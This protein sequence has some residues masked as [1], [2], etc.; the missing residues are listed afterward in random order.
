MAA[1]IQQHYTAEEYLAYERQAAYKSEYIAGQILAMSGASWE[2]SPS[3]GNL[4]GVLSTQLRDRPGTVHASALRVKVR[5]KGMYSYPDLVVV[6]G[7][8]QF[9]DSQLDTLLNPTVIIEV[10]SPSTEAYDR[11]AKFGYYRALPSLH[12]YLL[13]AQDKMLIEHYVRAEETWV[14]TAISD[15]AAV[16]R[17]PAIDCIVPLAEIYRKVSFPANS[18]VSSQI[19]AR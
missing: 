10:L 8:P 5:T 3:A 16:L 11:G 19:L 1:P 17:L 7:E 13:I 14:L 12:E 15:P 6:C 2:H 9:E 18:E 4:L